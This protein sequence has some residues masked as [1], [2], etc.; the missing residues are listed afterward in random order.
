MQFIWGLLIL[1]AN[2][3]APIASRHPE[4]AQIFSCGF[5]EAW[6]SNYDG[7]PEG[8][9]RKRSPDFP[10]YLAVRIAQD[11]ADQNP[12]LRM[13]LNGGAAAVFSPAIEVGAIFSYVL[14]GAVRTEG[15]RNDRAWLS[16]TFEDARGNRLETFNSEKVA[17]AAEWKTLRLAPVTP[18]KA[19]A[20]R[21]VIGLH[22]EPLEGSQPDLKG[23]A[24]FDSLWLGRLPRMTVLTG[25]PHNIYTR[26]DQIEI[27]CTLSGVFES[28]PR[29][30]V[31]LVDVSGPTGDGQAPPIVDSTEL[32]I[33]RLARQAPRDGT[34]VTV[35]TRW[36]PVVKQ[37]GLYRV[38]LA[39]E[40]A[41]G[42]ILERETTLALVEPRS[43]PKHGEFGWSLPKQSP[44]SLEA[45]A[46]V[47]PEAGVNW[48]K[49]PVW[50]DDTE[51]QRLDEIVSFA[52]RLGSE[53]IETVALLCDPPAAV[54]PRFG[55]A[56]TLEAAD[57]FSTS[58]D[59]WY[60]ALEPIITRLSLQIRW[61]QLGLDED[62]S[63]VGYPGFVEKMSEVKKHLEQFGREVHLGCGWKMDCQMPASGK[64]AP[65]DFVAMSAEPAMTSGELAR[66]L[67]TPAAAMAERW[68]VLEPLP[69]SRYDRLTRVRDLVHRMLA[70]KAAGAR[71]I[72]VPAPFDAEHGLMNP[73]G[74][75]GDLL[76]PWRTTA[77]A[78]AGAEC[79]GSI[80]LPGDSP[81]YVFARDGEIVMVVWNDRPTRETLSLSTNFAHVDLWG[82]R[83]AVALEP[84]GRP[85]LEVGS[86]PTFVFGLTEPVTRWMLAA[87]FERSKLPTIFGTSQD[88]ALVIK[89]FF[90]QGVGGRATLAFPE[91]WKVFPRTAEFKLA[92]DEEL[93]IPIAVTL[94]F[95]TNNGRQRVRIDFEAS[96]EQP[97]AFSVY[98]DLEIGLDDI[99]LEVATRIN[100][101]GELEVEQNFT[102]DAAQPV[103]FKCL[104]FVPDRR[105]LVAQV[106]QLAE[107][108]DTKIYRVPNGR[109]L[110]GKT[111]L[112]RAEEIGGQRMLNHRF[113]ASE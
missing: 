110:L 38:R 57:I 77:Q 2:P 108:R 55:E 93:H 34:G 41:S 8:W 16:I 17:D 12:C 82:R 42:R 101:K 51:M 62:T 88:N 111:L 46:K 35:S 112:I 29:L 14:E 97:Y 80:K 72:S 105:R 67:A 40:G 28:D 52:E 65:W 21:A 32:P 90:P 4:A 79:L 56:P 87:K 15:L 73:D 37:P 84:D 102:N 10:R 1:A 103:N 100:A 58:A 69:A 89:N 96:A 75:A 50:V 45:L 3:A 98:R 36:K 39:L 95:D 31:E 53:H 83:A 13:E 6:D 20:R 25:C 109:E 91:S 24:Q 68:V 19:E 71:G 49:L 7:W 104:L 64:R 94:P 74:T 106:L 27:G 59:V 33:S 113:V 78:L 76:L 22:L 63:F 5:D 86:L 61:W 11:G 92:A 47:L 81:N 48:V 60:A 99:R 70:A 107:Q 9:T 44:L 66:Y 23:A 30:R 85:A 26:A 54:R 18:T 43:T